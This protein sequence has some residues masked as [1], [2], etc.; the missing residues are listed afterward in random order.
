VT[1][2]RTGKKLKKINT[3]K[4]KNKNKFA[5]G[6]AYGWAAYGWTGIYSLRLNWDSLRLD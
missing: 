1:T 5:A 6:A 3:N 4:Y 2:N